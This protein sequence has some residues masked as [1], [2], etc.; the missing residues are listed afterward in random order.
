MTAPQPQRVTN[1]L[2]DNLNELTR[3]D[4]FAI[5]RIQQ[6]AVKLRAVDPRGAMIV[7]AATYTLLGKSKEA[8]SKVR[9][10]IDGFGH[11]KDARWNAFVAM[12]RLFHLREAAQIAQI[13]AE[14]FRA[15]PSF[16]ED[17]MQFNVLS[18]QVSMVKAYATRLKELSP[19]SQ[20]QEYIDMSN[21]FARHAVRD[22]DASAVVTAAE[23]IYR[24]F[25]GGYFIGRSFNHEEH[26]IND[27]SGFEAVYVRIILD[28]MDAADDERVFQ[29]NDALACALADESFIGNTALGRFNMDFVLRD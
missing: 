7:E 15:T 18:G 14:R 12:F 29:L 16:M 1:Q 19:E 2:I 21:L 5:R 13:S 3:K 27:E 28:P 8:E 25:E 10:L 4:D 26:L 24:S 20:V 9:M 6:E 17:A 22:A 23:Q 11:D